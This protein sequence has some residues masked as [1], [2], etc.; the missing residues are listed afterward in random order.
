MKFFVLKFVIIGGA[1][2]IIIVRSVYF[3]EINSGG[4]SPYTLKADPTTLEY[5][6][7]NSGSLTYNNIQTPLSGSY[8]LTVTGSFG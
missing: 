3:D 5:R 6:L 4:Y 7:F 8:P 1:T 2:L